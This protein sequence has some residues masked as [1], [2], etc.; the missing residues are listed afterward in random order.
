MSSFLAQDN[1]HSANAVCKCRWFSN[2]IAHELINRSTSTTLGQIL[3]RSER[4]SLICF[5]VVLKLRL[6][7]IASRAGRWYIASVVEA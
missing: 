3:T 1:G 7:L 2:Y 5:V 4:G 6:V